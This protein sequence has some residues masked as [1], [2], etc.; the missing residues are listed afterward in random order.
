MKINLRNI[1]ILVLLIAIV[2]TFHIVRRNSTMRGIES[3]VENVRGCTLLT[4]S[5]VDSLLLQSSPSLL[6]TDIKDIEKKALRKH[7]ESHPYVLKASVGLTTGGKLQVK[8]TPRVPV[9]RMFYQDNEF[10]ISREGTIMPL[11][12]NHY[13]HV[14]VGNS[15][16]DE[17]TQNRLTTLHL[18]DTN[19]YE[20]PQTLIK[21]W[22]LAS[23][24]YDNPQY[25]ELFDQAT[26]D[27]NGDLQ[28]SPKL[29]DFTVIVGDETQ[30]EQK[31][32]NFDAFLK[33]GVSQVG[34]DT[35]S[36]INLKYR[37]QVVGSRKK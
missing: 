13:C 37:N 28:L 22:T 17:P 24:L 21:L 2:F 20:R 16:K 33:Q 36:T 5:D 11:C 3:S 14:M 19:N 26:L 9:L 25:G 34:W 6:K 4:P 32:E 10:Y 27:S 23:F 7:L 31:F 8:V 12:R 18:D 29:G 35:Y 15:L 30:L 1:I